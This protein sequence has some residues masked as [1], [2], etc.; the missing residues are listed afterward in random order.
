MLEGCLKPFDMEYKLRNKNATVGHVGV[1]QVEWK[2]LPQR[3]N[4]INFVDG[5]TVSNVDC[6]QLMSSLNS[7]PV[8]LIS[9]KKSTRPISTI[10]LTI[11]QLISIPTLHN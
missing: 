1:R 6:I 2:I 3:N 10:L 8:V 11:Q 7:S 9:S 5:S 4:M